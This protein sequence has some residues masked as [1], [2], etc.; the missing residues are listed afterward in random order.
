MHV[1]DID[2]FCVVY[3]LLQEA[4][5]MVDFVLRHGNDLLSLECLKGYEVCIYRLAQG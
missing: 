2:V 3:V 4:L 5:K 1:I